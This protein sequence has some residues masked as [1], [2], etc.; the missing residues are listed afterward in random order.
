ME[1]LYNIYIETTRSINLM[2]TTENNKKEENETDINKIE[3]ILHYENNEN[4]GSEENL[5]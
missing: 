5:K 3:A 2:K 1:K 4:N